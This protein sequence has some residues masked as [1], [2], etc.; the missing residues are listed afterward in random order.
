MKADW[1][2]LGGTPTAVSFDV[3]FSVSFDLL[4]FA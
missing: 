3:L 1:A 4:F 2:E